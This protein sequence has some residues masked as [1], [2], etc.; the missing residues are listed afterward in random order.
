MKIQLTKH[1]LITDNVKPD[2]AGT[3]MEV[4]KQIN[5]DRAD[6]LLAIGYAIKVEEPEVKVKPVAP[7]TKAKPAAPENKG[8]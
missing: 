7:D 8:K 5:K 2:M 4:G 6:A 1:A 3:I